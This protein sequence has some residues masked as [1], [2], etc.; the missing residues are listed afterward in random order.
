MKK[1]SIKILLVL[2]LA[3]FI[4]SSALAARINEAATEFTLQSLDGKTV[5]LGD[6]KGKVIF[7]DFWASWCFPCKQELPELNKFMNG[8]KDKDV[9]VLAVNIDK[10][11][12]HAEDFLIGMGIISKGFI[13][14]LDT[15][16]KTIASYGAAAMPTS[17]VI[18]RE[19]IVRY[20]HF[21]YDESDPV[22][23]FEEINVLLKK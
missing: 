4:S 13:V 22:K 2:L 20:V 11:R 1:Y 18:D 16:S 8:M 17:F 7:L 6:F 21:G 15:D 12:S 9:V 3:V 14:L 19:G 23:W 5:R 10:K